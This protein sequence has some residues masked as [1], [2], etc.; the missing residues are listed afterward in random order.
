[1]H[2]KN[3]NV[4]RQDVARKSSVYVRVKFFQLKVACNAVEPRYIYIHFQAKQTRISCSLSVFILPFAHVCLSRDLCV[5][6]AQKEVAPL[7]YCSFFVALYECESVRTYGRFCV[8]FFLFLSFFHYFN[9]NS[10]KLW[11]K[12][13]KS[14]ECSHKIKQ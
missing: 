5:H 14:A 9:G 4:G 1:M 12:G 3:Y 13:T 2:I 8:F 11:K 6:K 7:Y 10:V